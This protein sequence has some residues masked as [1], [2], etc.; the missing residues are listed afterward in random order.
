VTGGG[1]AQALSEELDMQRR[2]TA[3]DR[4]I[5]RLCCMEAIVGALTGQVN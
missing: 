5:R 3:S 2:A 1:D 4:G